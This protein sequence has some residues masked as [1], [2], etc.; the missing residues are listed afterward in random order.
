MK[1]SSNI[2]KILVHGDDLVIIT[3]DTLDTT[4]L[5]KLMTSFGMTLNMDKDGSS[6]AHVDKLYFLG[7]L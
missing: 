3:F 4:M 1:A 2:H 7:S 5:C 6:V